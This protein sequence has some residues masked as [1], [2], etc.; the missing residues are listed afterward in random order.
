MN[1]SIILTKMIAW[2]LFKAIGSMIGSMLKV[3]GKA[4]SIKTFR[5]SPITIKSLIIRIGKI[6]IVLMCIITKTRLIITLNWA[7]TCS[8]S[9]IMLRNAGF[10]IFSRCA[11]VNRI[12]IDHC[13][14]ILLVSRNYR[15]LMALWIIV[16][17]ILKKILMKLVL[18]LK[19]LIFKLW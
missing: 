18:H 17:L 16:G 4:R 13:N 12:W 8:W 7:L 5:P 9:I 14:I 3:L 11:I 2:L 1:W 19:L 10:G 15:L 6:S